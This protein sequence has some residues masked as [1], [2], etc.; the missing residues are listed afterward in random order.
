MTNNKHTGVLIMINSQ[1]FFRK[2]LLM[3]VGVALMMVLVSSA[4]AESRVTRS[5]TYDLQSI[6]AV[7]FSNSVGRIEFVAVD[8]KEMRITLDI[9]ARERGFFRRQPDVADMDLEARERG[10]TLFLSFDE[11]NVSAEW[12]VELPAVSHTSVQMGVGELRL[13]IGATALDVEL[14]VGDVTIQAPENT[15][16]R[17]DLN[18]GVGDARVRGAEILDSKSA[19]ISKSVRAEGKGANAIDVDLGVGDVSVRLDE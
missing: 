13:E 19:F 4:K 17:I 6:E 12:L 5:H 18:V 8:G 1:V 15:V 10:D 14:G 2:L 7:D 16:G 9:E 11:E 3:S